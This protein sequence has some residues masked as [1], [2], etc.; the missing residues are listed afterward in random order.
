MTCRSYWRFGGAL[1]LSALAFPMAIAVRS[2]DKPGSYPAKE[3]SAP[4]GDWAATRYSTLD[5]ITTKNIKQLGGA[6]VVDLPE[7]AEASPLVVDGRMFVVTANGQILAF[8]PSTGGPLWI[9]KPEVHLQGAS[10]VDWAVDR[11]LDA[12]VRHL[13]SSD[14]RLSRRGLLRRASVVATGLV[15]CQIRR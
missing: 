11:R 1:V 8:D 4:G 7:R 12:H 10:V 6:W 14:R 5:R 3:W 2:A 15:F 9:F 13:I